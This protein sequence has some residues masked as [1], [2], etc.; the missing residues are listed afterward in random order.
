M[1]PNQEMCMFPMVLGEQTTNFKKPLSWKSSGVVLWLS[2]SGTSYFGKSNV[3]VPP[4]H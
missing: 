4:F 2:A 3:G 1:A